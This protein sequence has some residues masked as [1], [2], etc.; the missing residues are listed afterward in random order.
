MG[1]NTHG[2]LTYDRG[3]N[4]ADQI[5]EREGLPSALI[6]RMLDAQKENPTTI[7][8]YLDRAAFKAAQEGHV[9]MIGH[10]Y[11]DTITALFTWMLE[12]RSQTVRMAPL[13]AIMRR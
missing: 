12:P 13:S 8:R 6:F 10:S 5:A 7:G 11:A 1:E 3:L 2:L 4:T 9:V